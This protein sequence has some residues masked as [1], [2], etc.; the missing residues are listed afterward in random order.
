VNREGR[1]FV[2]AA[3][4]TAACYFP[5][6]VLLVSYEAACSARAAWRKLRG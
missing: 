5:A 6:L 4:F 3:F 1:R 2:A